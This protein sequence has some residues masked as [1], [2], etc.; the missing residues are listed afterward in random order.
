MPNDPYDLADAPARTARRRRPMR[1]SRSLGVQAAGVTDH[2]RD[3]GYRGC[4][5]GAPIPAFTAGTLSKAEAPTLRAGEHPPRPGT[6]FAFL[7]HRLLPQ[8]HGFEGLLQHCRTPRKRCAGEPLR[9]WGEDPRAEN[10]VLFIALRLDLD[11]VDP[12]PQ[13]ARLDAVLPGLQ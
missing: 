13:F 8:P 2:L 11:A 1:R 3:N 7:R 6:T 10:E 9:R 4:T 12:G 5:S